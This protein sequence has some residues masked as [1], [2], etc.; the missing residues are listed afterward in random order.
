[1]KEKRTDFALSAAILWE[2]VSLQPA[3]LIVMQSFKR[4]VINEKKLK[5]RAVSV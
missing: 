5:N 4:V 1:M 3:V 2:V